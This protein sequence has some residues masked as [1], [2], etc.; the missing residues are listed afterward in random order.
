MAEVA[1]AVADDMHGRGVATLLLEHL[2]S[3]GRVA[4]V[5]NAYGIPVVDSCY[6][7][8]IT[9]A[10]E[11]TA[12]LG[13]HVALKADVPGLV[14]KSDA[15]AVE[16][17]VR[18]PAEVRRALGRLQGRF[19]ERLSGVLVQA[20]VSGGAETIIGVVQE[21][22]FGRWWCSAWAASPPTCSATIAPG[23]RR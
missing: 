1:F 7:T 21:P 19:G 13:G 9:A 4:I 10:L 22:V 5:T 15:G 3:A 23:S 12:A 11:A 16:L 20:M 18:G 17:D 8:G 2:V 14:H 6:V